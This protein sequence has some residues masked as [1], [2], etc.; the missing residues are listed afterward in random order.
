MTIGVNYWPLL[1]PQY[2]IDVTSR[3]GPNLMF[4]GALQQFAKFWDG[5][6]LLGGLD[7]QQAQRKAA[8]TVCSRK[9]SR[10]LQERAALL[11]QPDI[12]SSEL[13]TS[14]QPSSVPSSD[15]RSS[16]Q[17]GILCTALLYSPTAL[18]GASRAVQLCTV[19]RISALLHSASHHSILCALLK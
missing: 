11:A 17:P 5:A 6:L 19:Q 10:S 18:C 12:H 16:A 13:P 2:S 15:Q 8:T 14:A 4:V 7:L 3:G 9:R 1:S